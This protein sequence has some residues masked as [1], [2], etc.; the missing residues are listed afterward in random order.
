MAVAIPFI[1]MG[2]AAMGSMSEAN[3]AKQQAENQSKALEN[4]AKDLEAEGSYQE[5]MIRSQTPIIEGQIVA[6]AAGS[7]AVVN[8]GSVLD[9]IK[10]NAF[11]IEM[12]AQTTRRNYEKQAQAARQDAANARAGAP[13]QISTLLNVGG[14]AASGYASGMSMAGSFGG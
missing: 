12:D 9:V 5:S 6:G 8:T 7:G 1:M 2:M 4:Q 3:A 14:S 11:N 10:Q 13:T